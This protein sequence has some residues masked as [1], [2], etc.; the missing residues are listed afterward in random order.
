M[1]RL[2]HRR[3][4]RSH[5][6]AGPLHR[7]C[8]VLTALA[9]ALPCFAAQARPG[10]PRLFEFSLARMGTVFNIALYHTDQSAASDAAMDAFERVE[11]LEQ[12]FSDNRE[13]SEA[14]R[15][16]REAA[17]TAR[18][19]SPELFHVLESSLRFSRLTGGGAP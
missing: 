16:C 1:I 9:S 19:V 18:P 12:I 15:I 14:R 2:T 10:E 11:Q 6:E 4:V 13:N 7:L 5:G 17:G 8:L 3:T